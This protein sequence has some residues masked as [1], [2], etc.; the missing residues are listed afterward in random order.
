MTA[1]KGERGRR[2]RQGGNSTTD[3]VSPAVEAR[4]LPEMRRLRVCCPLESAGSADTGCGCMSGQVRSGLVRGIESADST[5]RLASLHRGTRACPIAKESGA[6]ML[7]SA[8]LCMR[9]ETCLLLELI[10]PALYSTHG[11]FRFIEPAAAMHSRSSHF[12]TET[13]TVPST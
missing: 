2:N 6:P 11:S 10:Q 3:V 7:G 9:V 4:R 13:Y 5:A 1:A 8:N 12:C